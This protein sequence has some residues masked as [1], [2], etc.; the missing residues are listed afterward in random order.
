MANV[1]GFCLQ[2]VKQRSKVTENQIVLY[3]NIPKKDLQN[4]SLDL[5]N[6]VYTEAKNGVWVCDDCKR[7]CNSGDPGCTSADRQNMKAYQHRVNEDRATMK[8]I[9]TEL[10][11]RI[12]VKRLME[13]IKRYK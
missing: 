8:D 3:V 5:I 6:D 11:R 9:I 13:D 10:D 1:C 4:M 7:L 2:H 12:N